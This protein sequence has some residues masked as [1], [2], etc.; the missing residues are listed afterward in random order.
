MNFQPRVIKTDKLFVRVRIDLEFNH[1]TLSVEEI[2]DQLQAAVNSYR[3]K[4][5]SAFV[6]GLLRITK[7]STYEVKRLEIIDAG[8][9]TAIH[10]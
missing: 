10:P 7:S 4:E 1:S 3:F 6:I 5:F 2:T 8:T 9:E